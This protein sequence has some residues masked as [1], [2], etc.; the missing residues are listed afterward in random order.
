MT[1]RRHVLVPFGTRPEVVKLAPVVH[2][3]TAAGHEVAVVDTGQHTDPALSSE[4]QD[5]LGLAPTLR[6][7]LPTEQPAR[8]GAL[9]ADAA[10][11]VAKFSPDLVLALGDTNTVPAYALAARGAGV[12]FGHVEAG[13]RSLNQRS[14]EEVNR[15]V[16]AASAQVHFAPTA[17]AAAFLAA[18]GVPQERIF[19]VGNPVIDTLVARG[20]APRP[21]ADRAGVLVTAHRPTNVDDPA[22]LARLVTVVR[23]LADTIGP[24]TF[25]VHPRTARRLEETGLAA[26][27]A[28]PGVTLTAPLDYDTLL[29]TLASS[30]L[31]VTDSGG[32]QE[33]AAYLGVPVVVLRASTPRWEGVEA[34]TTTLAGLADDDAAARVM[35]AATAHSSAAGQE[36]AAT[37]PCPY[38][39]GTTGVRIAQIL[40]DERTDALLALTEPDFTDGHLPW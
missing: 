2:A 17:R 10:A 39:D 30:R 24:V 12:P 4:L 20:V 15:K 13:L 35:A 26:D 33:E 28:H 16:A 31:A 5:A 11:A 27:L 40:A 18:E 36:R 23:G 9:H 32:I 7:S 29:A 38:G 6:F 3:L 1:R 14:I 22:R 21:V 37:L 19:V 25:P 34:G 8:T